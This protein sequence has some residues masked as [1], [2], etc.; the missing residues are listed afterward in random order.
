MAIILLLL[1]SGLTPFLQAAAD[2]FCDNV[3]VLADTLPKNTSSSPVHF[4]TAAFGQAPDVVY[5]LSLCRGDILN[6]TACAKC[7]SNSFQVVSNATPPEV[8]C[9]K[10]ANYY[11]DCLLV[12]SGDA[13]ILAPFDRTN[14]GDG[15]PPPFVKCN[16]RNV[17]GDVSLITGLIRELLVETV[18]TAAAAASGSGGSTMPRFAT[19]VMD[20][21]TNFPMVYSMAQCTPDMS[22]GDCLACLR[23]LLDMV[24]STMALRIGGQ[25]HVIRCY[26]RYEASQFYGGQPMVR[27]GPPAP[28]PALSPAT[29]HKRKLWVIPVVVV[30]LAAAAFLCFIFYS[31][32]RT[33]QRKGKLMRSQGSRRAQD[34]EGEEQLVWQGKN[35]EFSAFDFEQVMEA[36]NNFSEENK[37]GQGGFG[38]VY[39]V[40]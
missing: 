36:T 21:G 37:L 1:L 5:A 3:K 39:K 2:V 9:Y 13:Q 8:Q 10:D 16:V 12:Y 11:G 4:A 15:T 33:K 27:I 20:S 14:N 7:V 32:R 29:K 6:D 25:I 19:G 24:N 34:L 31:R 40:N 18:E 23:G 17:T 22:A 30:P 26:F 35:S 38:A 28:A